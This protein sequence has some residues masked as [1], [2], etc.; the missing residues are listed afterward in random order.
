MIAAV[1]PDDTRLGLLENSRTCAKKKNEKLMPSG[2]LK[3]YSTASGTGRKEAAIR[4]KN[5]RRIYCRSV[6]LAIETP[7]L[8]SIAATCALASST[9]SSS[10]R[11]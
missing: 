7:P 4:D 1:P 3:S 5:Q 10:N 11:H 8:P 2:L 6:E 9:L